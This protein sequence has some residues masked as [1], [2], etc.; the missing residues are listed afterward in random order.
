MENVLFE[1]TFAGADILGRL[2]FF[3]EKPAARETVTAII[4]S[5]TANAENISI[6]PNVKFISNLRKIIAI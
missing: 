4:I 1:T 5:K 6:P 3:F 2:T